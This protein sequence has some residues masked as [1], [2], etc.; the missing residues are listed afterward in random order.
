[1]KDSYK[2]WT[3]PKGRVEKGELIEEAAARETLEELGLREIR[4]LEDLGKID[5]WF[6]DRFEKQGALVHKDIHYF[7]F[8][9]TED[10]VLR[11]DPKEHVYGAEWI[12]VG[13][14]VKKSSYKDMQPILK[15]AITFIN[16]AG[17]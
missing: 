2:K 16:R 3:F 12:T 17:K 1:M 6:R 7:L 14:L 11:T 13:Q 15:K 5:I 8:E 9:T 4:L 10:A